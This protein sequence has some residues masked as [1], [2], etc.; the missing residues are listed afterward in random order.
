MDEKKFIKDYLTDLSSVIL[1]NEKLVEN[2]IKAKNLFLK[3]NAAGGKIMIFGNG[4]GASIQA[5]LQLIL[6]KMQKLLQ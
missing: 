2:L 3:T 6:Q 5:M 4:A 1:P